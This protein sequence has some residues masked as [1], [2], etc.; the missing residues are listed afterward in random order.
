MTMRLDYYDYP[1]DYLSGYRDRIAAVTREDVMRVARRYLDPEQ[2]TLVLVGD[3]D[4]DDPA[5]RRFQK[6]VRV[7]DQQ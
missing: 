1:A 5:L 7:F 3:V 4:A 2:Q 6:P